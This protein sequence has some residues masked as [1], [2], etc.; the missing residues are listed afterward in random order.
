LVAATFSALRVLYRGKRSITLNLKNEEGKKVFLDLVRTCDVVIENFSPGTMDRIGLGYEKLKEVNP[1]IVY[2]AISGFGQTGRYKS[3]PGYDI[4]SQ[5][6]TT[7]T[8]AL[9][10]RWCAAHESL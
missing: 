4:I 6:P 5:V 9:S 8:R 7:L 3:R 10:H 2:A 1:R